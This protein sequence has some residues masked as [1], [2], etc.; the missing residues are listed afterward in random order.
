MDSGSGFS[1]VTGLGNPGTQYQGTRH[2]FGFDVVD[3]LARDENVSWKKA[4]FAQAE[5]CRLG[6]GTWLAKPMTFMNASGDAVADCLEWFRFRPVQLLV[7]V[8]DIN[9]PLGCLRMKPAGSPGGHNGLKSVEHRLGTSEYARLRGGVG[10]PDGQRQLTGHVLGKFDNE[11]KQVMDSCV[12]KAAEA[13]LD[14][15]RL[16]LEAVMTQVNRKS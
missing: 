5:V 10:V 12:R 6:N 9:L 11:E 14:C 8:D 15:H 3:L 2:N 1:L 4:R 13:I 16:G 7:V